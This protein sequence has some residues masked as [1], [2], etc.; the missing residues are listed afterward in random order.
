MKNT[1]KWYALRWL[2]CWGEFLSG[3]A[4]VVTFGC[5]VPAWTLHA[6]NWFLSCAEKELFEKGD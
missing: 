1:P 2:A 5:W 4:G 6:D 3:L